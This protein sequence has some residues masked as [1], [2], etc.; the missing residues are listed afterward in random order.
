[1]FNNIYPQVCG[2]YYQAHTFDRSCSTKLS[3]IASQLHKNHN[4][5]PQ[6]KNIVLGARNKF[7]CAKLVHIKVV[8]FAEPTRNLLATKYGNAQL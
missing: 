8:N 3:H 6:S 5:T 2:I 1:M 7:K 4:S